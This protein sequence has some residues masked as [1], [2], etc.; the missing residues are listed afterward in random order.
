MPPDV[1]QALKNERILVT[2]GTGFVGT[3]LMESIAWANARLSLNA[4]TAAFTRSSPSFP[5]GDYRFIIHAAPETPG[6]ATV[7]LTRR[8]LEL[9][10]RSHTQKLLYTSSGAVYEHQSEYARLKRVSESVLAHRAVICRM[11]AFI[12]PYLR[13]DA[14]FAAG[15]FIRDVLNRRPIEVQGDGTPIRTYLYAADLTV[16]LL[17]MLVNGAGVYDVGGDAP[18]T[19]AELAQKAANLSTPKTAV[20][21]VGQSKPDRYVPDILR[22]RNELNLQTWTTIDEALRRTYNWHRGL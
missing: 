8:V 14:N 22:A 13:L 4:R 12:G 18:I 1:W 11:F 10:L 15:N 3:W 5:L 7:P 20:K 2:G 17:T 6:D 21:I 19:I 9:A 16:W